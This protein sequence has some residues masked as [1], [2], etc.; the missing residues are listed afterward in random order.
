MVAAQW[1]HAELTVKVISQAPGWEPGPWWTIV[2][3]LWAVIFWTLVTG[4][5]IFLIRQRTR[6]RNPGA[7][8]QAILAERFARGEISEQEYRERLAVLRDPPG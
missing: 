2:W 4:L 5:V 8:A 1:A 6:D 3:I 7:A